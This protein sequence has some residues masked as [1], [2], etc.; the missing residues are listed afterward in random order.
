MRYHHSI[1]NTI[2]SLPP[3]YTQRNLKSLKTHSHEPARSLKP[4]NDVICRPTKS[5]HTYAPT[6]V[7]KRKGVVSMSRE[8]ANKGHDKRIRRYHA[9]PGASRRLRERS[10][11]W[12]IEG[13]RSV[14]DRLHHGGYYMSTFG[15]FRVRPNTTLHQGNNI[16]YCTLP[17]P[18]VVTHQQHN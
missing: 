9:G 10:R 6:M 11:F 15:R 5:R 12:M 4:V 2:S 3:T 1:F 18:I 17:H 7:G 8:A 14:A 13:E 16:R